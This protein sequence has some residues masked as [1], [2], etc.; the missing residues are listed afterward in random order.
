MST[1][2]H[3][4]IPLATAVLVVIGHLLA[5]RDRN[6]KQEENLAATTEVQV[7]VNGRMEAL[8][9]RVGRLEEQL[10]LA[11]AALVAEVGVEAAAEAVSEPPQ[12]K[13]GQ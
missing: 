7:L 11:H 5:K 1:A 12:P 8:L 2:L 6:H 13:P 4:W 9:E 3:Q 10:R